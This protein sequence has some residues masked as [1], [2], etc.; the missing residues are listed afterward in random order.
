MVRT[1]GLALLRARVQTLVGELRSHKL[2]GM[3]K[4]KIKKACILS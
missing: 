1:L 2:H 4:K 3:A